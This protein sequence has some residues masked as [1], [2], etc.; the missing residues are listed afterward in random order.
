MPGGAI[1]V[2]GLLPA[3]HR[4]L[5]L[6]AAALAKAK[7]AELVTGNPEFKAVE[8]EIRISWLAAKG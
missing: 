2:A 8:K 1:K 6:F 5:I 3:L 7:K 4:L